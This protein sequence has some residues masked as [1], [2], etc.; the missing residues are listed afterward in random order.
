MCESTTTTINN[1]RIAN[2]L[3]EGGFRL[4]TLGTGNLLRKLCLKIV[5]TSL[6]NSPLRSLVKYFK[7]RWMVLICKEDMYL[8]T[9]SV[10]FVQDVGDT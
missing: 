1:T 9:S 6:N 5:K 7:I 8:S 2:N 4:V 3:K 10:Y